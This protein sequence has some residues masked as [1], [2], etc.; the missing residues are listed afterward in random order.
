MSTLRSV[1]EIAPSDSR[2]RV[3]MSYVEARARPALLELG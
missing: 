3:S 1:A 2:D